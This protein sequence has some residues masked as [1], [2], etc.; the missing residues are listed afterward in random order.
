M[1]IKEIMT[2]QPKTASRDTTLAAAAH[3]LWGAD[4]G[5]LPVVDG[6]KLVGV[7]TDRTC[8]SHWPRGTSQCLM[9][10]CTP[11]FAHSGFIFIAVR[12][13]DT[14]PTVVSARGAE[15]EQ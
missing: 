2:K 3:L 9:G 11:H 7:V 1:K 13:F 6:G 4:C 12:S 8:T 10:R 14:S 5:I 15:T